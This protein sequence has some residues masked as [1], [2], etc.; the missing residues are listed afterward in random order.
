MVLFEGGRVLRNALVSVAVDGNCCGFCPC[1]SVG[2]PVR[3]TLLCNVMLGFRVFWEAHLKK[4]GGG[5]G[6]KLDGYKW[7]PR[8]K[9][10]AQSPEREP[11]TLR[12]LE[13]FLLVVF[14]RAR[15]MVSSF[16]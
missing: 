8:E 2:H 7:L 3:C 13:S 6:W 5:A 9:E 11:V 16:N 14:G 12:K 4:D 15:S 1:G 10:S